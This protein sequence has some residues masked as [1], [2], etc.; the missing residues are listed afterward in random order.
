[1]RAARVRW[2]TVRRRATFGVLSACVVAAIWRMVADM[3]SEVLLMG[4]GVEFE[5]EGKINSHLLPYS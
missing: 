4:F 2:V 3:V 5:R 1:M